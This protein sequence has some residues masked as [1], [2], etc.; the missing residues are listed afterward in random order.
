MF[1]PSFLPFHFLSHKVR[2]T[3][4]N[5]SGGNDSSQ[6]VELSRGEFGKNQQG[7]LSPQH[8]VVS[9]EPLAGS[10]SCISFPQGP[11]EVGGGDQP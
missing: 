11:G 5:Y 8:T 3:Q 6:K 9:C 7:T 2:M 1:L 4:N 10:S